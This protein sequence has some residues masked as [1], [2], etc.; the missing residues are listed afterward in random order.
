[1]WYFYLNRNSSQMRYFKFELRVNWESFSWIAIIDISVTYIQLKNLYL[2]VNKNLSISP[3]TSLK[4]RLL[5]RA[6]LLRF[7]VAVRLFTIASSGITITFHSF[8]VRFPLWKIQRVRLEFYPSIGKM[9]FYESMKSI[10]KM[11]RYR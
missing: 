7:G 6:S 1:M 9:L 2:T 3:E 5:I 8:W 11:A 4:W 10:Q